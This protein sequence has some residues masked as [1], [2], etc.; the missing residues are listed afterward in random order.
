MSE[1]LHKVLSLEF[2]RTNRFIV[3]YSSPFEDI[4]PIITYKANRPI[5]N[6]LK[7]KWEDITLLLRDPI[8]PSTSKILIKGLESIK[9]RKK[10]R[11]E[12]SRL[13]HKSL[14][15][16][17]FIYIE[18]EM[19]DPTGVVVEKWNI[20]GKI[21]KVNFGVLDYTDDGL[22]HIELIFKVKSATLSI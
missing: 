12:I 18:I 22:S 14:I 19:L 16:P 11:K 8:F 21:K 3:K 5:Y 6:A 9:E 20:K 1:L 4:Q 13:E 7:S 17:E 2:K 10:Y 15:N